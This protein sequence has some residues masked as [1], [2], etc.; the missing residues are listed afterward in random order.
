MDYQFEKRLITNLLK[1]YQKK[2]D[3]Y[4]VTNFSVAAA[5]LLIMGTKKI[6]SYL[7]NIGVSALTGKIT[8]QPKL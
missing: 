6:I 8:N 3:L 5:A 7:W 4:F 2:F 1:K